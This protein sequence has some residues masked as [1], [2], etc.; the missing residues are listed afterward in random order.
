MLAEKIHMDGQNAVR[1]KVGL[2][3]EAFRLHRFMLPG[4]IPSEVIACARTRRPRFRSLGFMGRFGLLIVVAG[5]SAKAD[6]DGLSNSHV[7]RVA[8]FGAIGDGVADDAEA[9]EKAVS[10]LAAAAKPAVLRLDAGHTYRVASGAGHIINLQAQSKCR[11]EGAGSVLMLGG[12]RRGLALKNCSD[13]TVRGLAFDYGPLPFAESLVTAVNAKDR[14]VEIR[15]ADGFAMPPPG[16]PTRSGGEQAYFAMLWNQGRHALVSSHF[17]LADLIL[18]TNGPRAMRA[19]AEANFQGWS[20]IKPGVTRMT[21]P[22]RGIAHRH[23]A[24]AV[25]ELDG[26]KDVTLE[27]VDVWSAPWFACVVQR[28]E[29]AVTLRRVHVRPKPGTPRIASSWRDGIHVKGNRGKLLIEDCVLDGMNDDAFNIATFLSRVDAID[30]VSV[31]VHQNFPLCYIAW[32]VGDT[33]ACYSTNT[34]AI[35]GRARVVAVEEKPAK[36]SDHAPE[37]TLTLDHLPPGMGRGDQVWAVEAANPDTTLRGCTIRNSCR[38]QSRVTL[39]KC[40]VTAFLWFYGEN[41]EGP[42]PSGSLIRQCHLRVGRGN[43]E[44]AA[45]CDGWLHGLPK[46]STATG[47]SALADLRFEDNEIDGRLELKHVENAMLLRNRFSADHGRVVI[48]NSRGLILERNSL[49]E[50]MLPAER[51]EIADQASRDSV[52]VR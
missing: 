32:R 40:D 34:G 25:I 13:V 14:S 21:V 46:P 8:D 11:I 5:F 9:L 51:I 36:T 50:S 6:S 33:L 52:F 17:W 47:P 23:G 37:A 48:A 41:I 38:F 43:L 24:G 35:P 45:A 1:G 4:W 26:N 29:G 27:N 3:A 39:D 2:L 12:E 10:A 7:I 44:L 20:F 42:L 22:V 28:N 19:I 18:S 30:G 15:V 16:G 49:G 31:R